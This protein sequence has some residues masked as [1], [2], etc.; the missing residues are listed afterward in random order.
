MGYVAPKQQILAHPVGR[1]MTANGGGVEARAGSRALTIVV[2][3][4]NEEPL[5][6]TTL[7]GAYRITRLIAEGGM[8]A[9]YE[10]DHLRLNQRVAV[11]GMAR[12]LRPLPMQLTWAPVPKTISPQLTPMSSE[13]RS[14]VVAKSPIR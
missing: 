14:P 4:Y 7:D 3:A 10:A 2:P 13:T 5:I 6:A 8:S 12:C 1:M 11:R 9:V